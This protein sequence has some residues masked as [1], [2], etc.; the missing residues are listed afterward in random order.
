MNNQCYDALNDIRLTQ[1]EDKHILFEYFF[2]RKFYEYCQYYI[3][4]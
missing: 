1:F 4:I 2:D 3:E